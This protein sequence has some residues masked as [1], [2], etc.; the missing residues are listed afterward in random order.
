MFPEETFPKW[1]WNR[2]VFPTKHLMVCE[3][4]IGQQARASARLR[5]M[6]GPDQL[7][8]VSLVPGA[9]Q[10]AAVMLATN[11]D[12]ILLDH[13]MPDGNGQSLLNWMVTTGLG[14]RVAVVTFSGIPENN[15]RM[16]AA[17]SAH[18][19]DFHVFSKEDVLTGSADGVIRSILGI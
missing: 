13:D 5:D 2:A 7:L 10:A 11:V 18:F 3:D 8:Q 12:L 6:F 14:Q 9:R 19:K 16:S 15:R 1:D 17:S 4:N